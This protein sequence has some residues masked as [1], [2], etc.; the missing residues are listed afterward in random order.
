ME[1]NFLPFTQ[2]LIR[3]QLKE[4]REENKKLK[5]MDFEQNITNFYGLRK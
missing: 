1:F 4:L 2:N 3:D 5:G